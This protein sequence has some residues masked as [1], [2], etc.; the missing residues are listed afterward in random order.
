MTRPAL[1]IGLGGTGQWVLTYLKKDLIE[2]NNGV[3]PENVI[4]LSFDT[5]P[6]ASVG[7]ESASAGGKDKEVRIGSVRLET[8]T[9][10][11]HLG[12]DMWDLGQAVLEGKRRG[13]QDLPHIASWFAVERWL[14]LPRASWVLSSGAGQLRQFGRLG[15]FKDLSDRGKSRVWSKLDVAVSRLSKNLRGQKLEIIVVGS[16][17]GG[18]G[19][20][21]FLDIGLLA[22]ER[23]RGVPNLVRGYFCLP[24]VFDAEPDNDMKA[25]SFAA[26]R[27]LNRF[28]TV[29]ADF[30]MPALMYNPTDG[31]QIT[32]IKNKVFDACYLIDG[33]QGEERLSAEPEKVIFP[34]VADAISALLDDTA[35]GQYTEWVVSNLAPVYA[36]KPGVALYSAVGSHSF[37]IPIYYSQ[38]EFSHKLTVNLL[39]T[40]VK[41]IRDDPTSP[42]RVM[43][44]VNTSPYDRA[45]VGSDD[46]YDLLTKDYSY[47]GHSEAAT[48]F[49]KE[50]MDIVQNGGASNVTLVTA[51][52]K[53]TADQAKGKGRSWLTPFTDFGDRADVRELTTTIGKMAKMGLASMVK[54]SKDIQEE[55]RLAPRRFARAIPE[56]VRENY[57]GRD[58]Q[59]NDYGGKFGDTLQKASEL[60]LDI[61]KRNAQLWVMYTLMGADPN[62]PIAGKAG[63][64]GYAYDLLDGLGKR[65]SDF[66]EFMA[67]VD[68]KRRGDDP[69]RLFWQRECN[70]RRAEMEKQA[71]RKFLGLVVPP[72]VYQTQVSY[73]Q[74]E[75]ALIHVR[76]DELLHKA[77]EGTARQM[78]AYAREMQNELGRWIHL[79]A[80]GDPATGIT[81]LFSEL[82]D[83]ELEIANTAQADAK[84][85]A[86]TMIEGP[87]YKEDE[88]ELERLMRA[89]TWS[90]VPSGGRFTLGLAIES[91]EEG[92]AELERPTGKEQSLKDLTQRNLG[93]MLGYAQRR[94]D[95]LP[96][97]TRVTQR[98]AE[99][100]SYDAS[101]FVEA[102][103]GK[104]EPFF[105]HHKSRQGGAAKWAKLIRISMDKEKLEPKTFTFVQDIQRKLRETNHVDL[106]VKDQDKLVQVVGS[107]DTHKATAVYTDDLYP[108]ELFDAWDDC[109]AAYL[110]GSQ[111]PPAMNHNF[112]AE[113]TAAGYETELSQRR[114]Q[115]YRVL[116]P[117]VVMLLEHE[118]RFKQF[119]YARALGWITIATDEAD[120]W[121]ELKLP[122][123]PRSLMLTPRAA[124]TPSLFRAMRYYI[125]VGMDQAPRSNW[126]IK[127]AEV[128][129]ALNAEERTLGRD[130]WIAF[131]NDQL[132][133]EAD[134]RVLIPWVID[135]VADFGGRME[136]H[137]AIPADEPANYADAYEDLA[138][139]GGLMFEKRIEEKRQ[140]SPT[141]P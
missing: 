86:Q 25:R 141:K 106:E 30:A 125:L 20:G 36:A 23:A 128:Q 109:M 21:M 10:F 42:R 1:I 14:T 96:G 126:T 62:K 40:L 80:T 114:N 123:W 130:N 101:R 99:Q 83:R 4:L 31:L 70:S 107:S 28:M 37:K 19:S 2:S 89:V 60:Q 87:A 134:G 33:K 69:P 118:D 56:F 46:A 77:V 68:E 63:R 16:F 122:G 74:A 26:W 7:A 12:G 71:S 104:A 73:L 47:G 92:R 136:R 97:E 54:P 121:W 18:T 95:Q 88:A 82:S 39:E 64:I 139:V 120:V 137:E 117:W 75:Q 34:A 58:A 41:P 111:Y 133:K 22:R 27:E 91:E 61:F 93:T 15:L 8:N 57:G 112:P 103:G 72:Q 108:V 29:S 66:L 49:T 13:Q 52:V 44:V 131:L 59:G 51:C 3:L 129:Q 140:Q 79:L 119:L 53:G 135:H 11:I 113:A 67:K 116:H 65:L 48:L 35:G 24:R 50:I 9:E 110:K 124:T 84:L 17:A 43:R 100:F 45:K 138:A 32:D 55:P 90:V 105:A 98:L 5:M 76:M 102:L 6:Q 115:E 38:Q 81:G 94:F 85:D 132:R 127:Y 78:Q